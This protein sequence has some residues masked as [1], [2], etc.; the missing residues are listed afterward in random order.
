MRLRVGIPKEYVG[1]EPATEAE[2]LWLPQRQG[3]GLSVK[4]AWKLTTLQCPEPAENANLAL[5]DC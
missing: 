5:W 1:T 2:M 3:G 4:A